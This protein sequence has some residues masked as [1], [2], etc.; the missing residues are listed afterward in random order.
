MSEPVD[1]AT[2]LVREFAAL[3]TATER[4]HQAIADMR[5]E[6]KLLSSLL[7][8]VRE[9]VQQR[10]ETMIEAALTPALELLGEK[11]K[12]AMDRSVE[13]VGQQIDHY[14]E[15]ALGQDALAKAKG[16]EPIPDLIA[17][18]KREGRA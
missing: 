4:A 12:E 7:I 15:L 8:E 5:A 6:R 9:A 13:R 10:A 16:Y 2:Q 1:I 3:N 17:R 11:T 18:V 14:L